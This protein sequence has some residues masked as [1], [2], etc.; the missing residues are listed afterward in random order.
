MDEDFSDPLGLDPDA[1]SVAC[2]DFFGQS[3]DPNATDQGGSSNGSGGNGSL[4]Q[5][6]GPEDG[7]VPPLPSGGC[8]DEFPVEKGDG[9]F[10]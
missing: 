4:M 8:P 3:D 5:S 10:R 2:E 6:G 9:C 1:N 7:P